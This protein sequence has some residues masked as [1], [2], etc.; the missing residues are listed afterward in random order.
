MSEKLRII[1]S[2]N[3][4]YEVQQLKF[5]NVQDGPRWFRIEWCG[6]LDGAEAALSRTIYSIETR[7][8]FKVIKEIEV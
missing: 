7:R 8:N 1:E 4:G 2:H 3:G 5:E 6:T